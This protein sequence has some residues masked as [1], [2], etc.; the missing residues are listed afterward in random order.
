MSTAA[1]AQ[2]VQVTVEGNLWNSQ[3]FGGIKVDLPYQQRS[4]Y[5][6]MVGTNP[7]TIE[8]DSRARKGEQVKITRIN[9][10]FGPPAT[11]GCTIQ[12]APSATTLFISA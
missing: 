4:Y 12:Q 3:K 11:N 10:D 8:I 9:G 6:D 2:Q 7:F 5:K 1:S